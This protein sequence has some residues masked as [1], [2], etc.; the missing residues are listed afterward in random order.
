VS[1]IRILVAEDHPAIRRGIG[2]ILAA[3]GD[4]VIAH[5]A[6]DGRDLLEHARTIA[7]DLVLLDLSMPGADG[8]SLLTQLKRERPSVPILVLTMHAE[9]QYAM[10]T[11]KAG[12]SGYLMKENTPATLVDAVR[13]IAAGG[14]YVSPGV[15]QK[16]LE[17]IVVP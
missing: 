8:L 12:A 2:R 16:L 11:L 7:H 10:R 1:A 17:K 13:T 3:A 15:D 6:V 4:M 9:D 5:E 14:R